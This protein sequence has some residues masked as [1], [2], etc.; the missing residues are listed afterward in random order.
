[1]PRSLTLWLHLL[2]RR[3]GTHE[4]GG[5][6]PAPVAR[7]EGALIWLH[8]ARPE[9]AP[10]A[11]YLVRQ[12]LRMRP[13]V[14][15]L[16]TGAADEVSFPAEVLRAAAPADSSP[17]AR[18]ALAAWRPDLFVLVGAPE[19]GAMP[20]AL[21][22]EA[23]ARDVPLLLLEARI[24]PLAGNGRLPWFWQRALLRALLALFAAVLVRDQASA[25]WFRR[26]GVAPERVAIAGSMREP[27]EPLP[28]TEAERAAL[29]HQLQS[30]PVWFAVAVPE[31]E[32]AALLEAQELALMRAHRLLLV[33]MPETG[34]RAEQIAAAV[35]ARGQHAALRAREEEPEDDVQVLIVE[36]ESE[37]GLW[38]RLAPVTWMG[39]TLS[40]SGGARSPFEAAALGSA[41]VHGPATGHHAADYARLAEAGACRVAVTPAALAEVVADLI[42][43]DR[44]AA[45]VHAAWVVI[46]GDAGVAEQVAGR[47][48]AELDAAQARR[49]AEEAG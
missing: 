8:Q 41:I 21:I 43:P 45:L 49:G 46:S 29:A 26:L 1:M 10:A 48:L 44:V 40:A 4:A 47:V 16:I 3:G 25:N 31:A 9:A 39:G 28:C 37:L 22:A 15:V 2:A 19:P 17:A 42:A 5:V 12:M 20:V 14:S 36:D 11:Q 24:A 32:E 13:G 30:R 18:A 35:E 23:S 34:G 27:V 38:Y 7:P 33:L 6:L